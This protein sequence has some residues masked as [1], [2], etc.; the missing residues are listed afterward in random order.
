M[1]AS[2]EQPGATPTPSPPVRIFRAWRALDRDQRMIAIAA[3]ALWITL[4]CPWYTESGF[5][6]KG[7][8]S[9]TLSAWSSFGLVQA[10][11]LLS[12][13]GVL[14]LLFARGEGRRFRLPGGD[15]GTI[16]VLGSIAAALILFGMFAKPGGGAI[17]KVA[18]ITSGVSWGIFLAL[19]AAVWLA[20]SGRAM[21]RG[22]VPAAGGT[23]PS[24]GPPERL[25][26]R[27]ERSGGGEPPEVARWEQPRVRTDPTAGGGAAA[28]R[29]V[30]DATQLSLEIP[31]HL[32]D[33]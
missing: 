22:R 25:L 33:E 28:P 2:A 5:V 21:R 26:T 6:S 24:G 13:L 29:P 31:R 3:M 9:I 11:V 14:A 12:S 10:Y 15:G 32:A 8:S 30:D 1:T 7:P 27:R 17:S 16:F 23:P 20:W 19:L 18:A 4:F